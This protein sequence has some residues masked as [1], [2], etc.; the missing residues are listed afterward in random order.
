VEAPTD[1]T[2][3]QEYVEGQTANFELL[4]RRHTRELFQFVLRFTRSSMAAEDVVQETFL[5]VHLSA[6]S[7]DFSR[8][9]KPWLFTIGANKARDYLRSRI[10]KREP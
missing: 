10:R 5:Q 6:G 4:V 9:F 3:L 2:L 8:R 7:F 1:E